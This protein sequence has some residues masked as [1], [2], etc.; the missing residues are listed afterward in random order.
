MLATSKM[1]MIVRRRTVKSVPR[2]C[3]DP[4]PVYE[5]EHDTVTLVLVHVLV[6]VN[7]AG[8]PRESPN[9]C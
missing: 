6:L 7:G 2:Q 5:H 3:Y 4:H 1:T 9:I 8:V